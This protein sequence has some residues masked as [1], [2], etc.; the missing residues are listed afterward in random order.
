MQENMSLARKGVIWVSAIL[1][2]VGYCFQSLARYASNNL[3][4]QIENVDALGR[5]IQPY[6]FL[7]AVLAIVV[8]Y[9]PHKMWKRILI[10]L[11]YIIAL[12]SVAFE[13]KSEY[14][15]NLEALTLTLLGFVVM[16]TLPKL[17]LWKKVFIG[18][19]IGILLGFDI[20]L[21]MVPEFSEYLKI[22]GTIFIDLI[23]M[24]VVPLIFFS[25]VSGINNMTDNA[26]GRVGVKAVAIYVLSAMF[27]IALGLVMALILRPGIGIDV[28]SLTPATKGEVFELPKL[29]KVL[30]HFI[31]HNALGAMSGADGK[32]E[33]VQTVFFAIFVG[34]TLNLMGEQGKRVVDLCNGA[35]Q[36]MFKMIGH[37]IKLAPLA[38]FGLM[39]W[40]TTNL[41]IDAI[42]QLFQLVAT[43]ISTMIIHLFILG[44]LI[45]VLG[46]LNPIPFFIK[47]I[48][49]QTLA[50]STSSSKAT[51]ATAMKIAEEKIGISRSSTSF[52]LPLGAAINMDGTA[53]YLGICAIFFAQIFNVPLELHHYILIVFA[54]TVASIGAAGYPGGSL[55]MMPMVLGAIDLPPE[56]ITLGIALLAGVD[57]ILDM[58]RT[59]INVTS[60]VALT[61]IIDRT[62]GTFNT[63]LYN[64]PNDQ[65]EGVESDVDYAALAAKAH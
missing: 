61:A 10:A 44:L 54:A 40:V 55:V 29:L 12:F 35:A 20:K 43:T 65:I 8:W 5:S 11:F 7:F 22:L 39:A 19:T 63:T 32:P 1:T 13:W 18:F 21:F 45:L 3:N 6:G 60:D 57:R 25:L 26:L 53:I 31:P 46:R 17:E 24:I 38:V 23:M 9:P 2:L 28:T 4:L 42:L 16:V 27:A 49:Y 41:G 58:F 59:T 56:Q 48:E 52:V 47:S 51:L 36:L 37:I 14:S 50:F 62:E 15:S 33:I 30:L 64:T 34:V